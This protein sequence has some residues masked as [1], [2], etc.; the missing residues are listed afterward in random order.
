MKDEC[1][2]GC[3]GVR[4]KGVGPEELQVDGRNEVLDVS[5]G[6]LVGANAGC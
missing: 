6:W 3:G 1:C 5:D 2:G 4:D